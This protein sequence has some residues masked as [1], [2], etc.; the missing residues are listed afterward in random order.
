MQRQGSLTRSLEHATVVSSSAA[1]PPR[2]IAHEG[3]V[4]GISTTRGH[5]TSRSHLSSHSPYCLSMASYPIGRGQSRIALLPS[6]P[7]SAERLDEGQTDRERV[8]DWIQCSDGCSWL[9]CSALHPPP[10]LRRPRWP[11]L[12][13]MPQA[14]FFPE[15]LLRPRVRR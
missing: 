1:S 11:A 6:R 3:S 8:C 7:S 9:S 5:D 15:S 14:P 10:H 12:S 13:E 4:R 2:Y